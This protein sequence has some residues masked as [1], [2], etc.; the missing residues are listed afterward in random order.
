MD[1]IGS[2]VHP[3]DRG[4]GGQLVRRRAPPRGSARHRQ[5]QDFRARGASGDPHLQPV[6]PAAVADRRRPRLHRRLPPHPRRRR[7]SRA[8]GLGRIP[9]PEGRSDHHRADRLRPIASVAGGRRLPAHLPGDRHPLGDGPIAWS[10]STKTPSTSPCG[11]APSPTAVWSRSNWG[12]SATS[13]APARPTSPSTE[14]RATSTSCAI[15][16][17]SISRADRRPPGRGSSPPTPSR[18]GRD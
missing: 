4:R 12:P 16:S 7:R 13:S 10:T 9:H 18:R 17:A 15:T 11:S 8:H 6:G 14:R 3:L 5:P 1:P 2:H